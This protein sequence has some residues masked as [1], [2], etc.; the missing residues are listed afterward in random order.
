[1]GEW[2]CFSWSYD[3][4]S[5]YCMRCGALWQNYQ[6]TG[7]PY[8]HTLLN[9]LACND[10]YRL[11]LEKI[12]KRSTN[13]G[14]EQI[15]KL[16][17]GHKKGDGPGRKG[18]QGRIQ[19]KGKYVSREEKR[20]KGEPT[21]ERKYRVKSPNELLNSQ[22]IQETVKRMAPDDPA[23]PFTDL[24]RS[25]ESELLAEVSIETYQVRRDTSIDSTEFACANERQENKIVELTNLLKIKE[26]E[27]TEKVREMKQKMAITRFETEAEIAKIEAQASM[28]TSEA[29]LKESTANALLATA[30][31]QDLI[32]KTEDAEKKKKEDKAKEEAILEW[33]NE[34]KMRFRVGS[35]LFS[36][37]DFQNDFRRVNVP[38]AFMVLEVV[39]LWLVFF[40]DSYFHFLGLVGLILIFPFDWYLIGAKQFGDF[41]F[42]GGVVVSFRFLTFLFS[43]LKVEVLILYSILISGYFVGDFIEDFT[44]MIPFY[45]LKWWWIHRN[46]TAVGLYGGGKKQFCVTKVYSDEV[47]IGLDR[48]VDAINNIPVRHNT[49]PVCV[50]SFVESQCCGRTIRTRAGK[51]IKV[52]LEIFVQLASYRNLVYGAT[53][54]DTEDRISS[55]SRS[56]ASVNLNRFDDL[57]KSAIVQSTCALVMEK[58]KSVKEQSNKLTVPESGAQALLNHDF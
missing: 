22:L 54:K 33:E 12:Q 35:R 21:H 17:S 48:R 37:S 41:V 56:L 25:N 13:A 58:W 18:Q 45:F 14:K 46:L 34:Q 24:L 44:I 20:Q 49:I 19:V 39:V 36:H 51:G 43:V 6:V 30:Q 1:M 9:N 15:G 52:D 53:D 2:W 57:K 27:D 7:S 40:V 42:F 31:A 16:G 47:H 23:R 8:W 11:S 5:D 28:Q 10:E 38:I 3:V 55:G 26:L 29:R 4:E 50:S 32:K